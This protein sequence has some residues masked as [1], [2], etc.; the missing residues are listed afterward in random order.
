MNFSREMAMQGNVNKT[1]KFV[2][3]NDFSHLCVAAAKDTILANIPSDT[4]ISIL[5]NI[6]NIRNKIKREL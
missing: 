2:N 1:R 4:L 3:N 6:F 5:S